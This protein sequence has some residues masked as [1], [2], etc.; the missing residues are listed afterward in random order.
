VAKLSGSGALLWNTFLGGTGRDTGNGIALDDNFN[1]YVTGSSNAS[2]GAPRRSYKGSTDAFVARLDSNGY[3]QWNTFLGSSG[4]DIGQSIR[5][6]GVNP[7][8]YVTGQSYGSWGSPVNAHAGGWDAFV[9]R[10]GLDGHMVWN[11]FMGSAEADWGKGILLL[12]DRDNLSETFHIYVIGESLATWGA[13]VNPHAGGKDV[14]VARLDLNGNISGLTFQGSSGDDHAAG[15]SGISRYGHY[16][17][18]IFIAGYSSGSWGEPINPNSGGDDAFVALIGQSNFRLQWNTFLGTE[19]EDQGMGVA[20][21]GTGN[22]YVA[23]YSEA[24]WGSPVR[25]FRGGW[26][27][28]AAKLNSSGTLLW[29][30]FLGSSDDDYG[31]G[32]AVD[33]NGS[34]YVVGDSHATWG[35]PRLPHSGQTDAFVAKLSN[36]GSLQ[37]NTFLGSPHNDHGSGISLDGTGNIYIVGASHSSWGEPVRAAQGVDAFVAKLNNNGELQWNTFLGSSDWDHGSGIAVDGIGY[38]YVTGSS[39]STWGTPVRYH[40]GGGW[41][42]AFA[43]KLNSNGELQ[44]NTFLGSKNDDYGSGIGVDGNR[45]V[46]V[47]GQSVSNSW[48]RPLRAFSGMEDAFVAR[49]NRSGSLVWNT[50]LGS[51]STDDGVGIAV[52][53]LGQV[54]VTGSSFSKW[55]SPLRNYSGLVD[56]FVG[57]LSSSG[58]LLWHSFLGGTGNDFGQGIGVRA[59]RYPKV[60]VVGSSSRNWRTPLRPIK[61]GIDAFVVNISDTP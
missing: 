9:A 52:T 38:V 33:D 19:Y 24:T 17:T 57:E 61:G 48:G 41:I 51:G 6:G 40:G 42:D 13:P 25:S 34:V 15:C 8:L 7:G 20:V 55:G 2:W 22:V 56:A 28:F 1:V 50:F 10:L 39:F 36:G 12:H 11:T 44:W 46:Y 27:A 18:D 3:L 26:D 43:A 14:F 29:N 49:L 31:R 4:G 32:I 54:Y 23:G 59:G 5:V 35:S 53:G 16:S 58:K 37:W 21:D 45:N 47:I 60:A 30:T